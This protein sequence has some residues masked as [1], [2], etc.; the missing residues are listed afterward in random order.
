LSSRTPKNKK[1]ALPF[2][3]SLRRRRRRIIRRAKSTAMRQGMVSSTLMT[4]ASALATL[5]AR[6]WHLLAMHAGL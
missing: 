5:Q 1:I 6:V 2:G 3:K 4:K